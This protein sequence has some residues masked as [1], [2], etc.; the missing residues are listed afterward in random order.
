MKFFNQERVMMARVRYLKMEQNENI[1][2]YFG[3]FN[4]RHLWKSP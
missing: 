4:Q 3:A 1:L 2:F